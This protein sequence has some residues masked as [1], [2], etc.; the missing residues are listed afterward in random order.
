MKKI[1]AVLAAG[2]MLLA[3][4]SKP[5]P[6]PEPQ[7]TGNTREDGMTLNLHLGGEPSTI[8]PAF[9][10]ADNGGS[11]VLHLFE[12]LTALDKGGN[13]APAAAESWEVEEDEDGLPVYTF[14]LRKGAVWSDGVPVKAE[15][16]I[17]AWLRMLDP[18]GDFPN[19]YLLYPIKNAQRYREGVPVP[20]ED[21]SFTI[22]KS[23]KAEE[24]GLE[25]T[26]EGA[27]K[28]TLEG[29]CPDFLEL[30][31][32][33]AWCPVRQDAVEA[34]PSTWTQSAATCVT[35]GRYMLSEWNH[36]Q[37]LVLV[38][39]DQHWDAKNSGD[40][41]TFLNFVL[42]EDAEAVY[43]DFTAGRLQYA[44]AIPTLD[45]EA[46]SAAGTFAQQP[47][48]GVYYYLF[49]TAKAPF[50]DARVRQ[51]VSLAIDRA[52][53]VSD[54]TDL[55]PVYGMVPD[56]IQDTQ[57]KKD[58]SKV[59][60]PISGN[61]T[62]N[63][64]AAQKLLSEAGY[65]GGA[66]FPQLRFITN[67]TPAHLEAAEKVRQMLADNLGIDMAISALSTQDFQA[68]RAGDGWDMARAGMVGSRTDPAP[69]LDGWSIGGGANYGSFS[70][71]E[72][73]RLLSY[74]RTA[75]ETPEELPQEEESD[76]GATQ[77]P[78]AQPAADA[79][80]AEDAGEGEDAEPEPLRLTRMEALHAMDK[81][82]VAEQA[83]VV[84]LW[85]YREPALTA[86]GLTGV[87]STPLG[88]RLFSYAD[89]DPPVEE[90]AEPEEG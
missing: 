74:S 40:G 31:A 83:A 6:P 28:V 15:D 78:A 81:L 80:S 2:L 27:L 37:N 23:V 19:A 61:V 55:A 79:G 69:Y 10:T 35:N 86:R 77:Q 89:W 84:P 75:P 49:N 30:L 5:E 8:D 43:N 73:D 62:A 85:Q 60:A 70:N 38:Q 18:E 22:E 48:A 64:S 26:E 65:P 7:G 66:G 72:Y 47:R 33:P 51:A 11:Y 76:A 54:G 46:E 71:E 29:P 3:A 13:P 88:Y 82:L 4:C 1:L 56:G 87:V 39:N 90:E 67:D 36:D 16:F 14:T 12:G 20:G 25:V 50:D 32:S 34:N 63:I 42:S 9:A 21:G 52:A 17:Y 44:S 68:S 59:S 58:F 45:R 57:Q 41:A 53:L 24:V